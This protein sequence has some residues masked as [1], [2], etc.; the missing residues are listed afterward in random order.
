MSTR[1]QILFRDVHRWTDDDGETQER[2]DEVLTYKHHD[3]YPKGTVPTLRRY[4]QYAG[5]RANDFEYFVASWPYYYKRQK[6]RYD[7]A[8]SYSDLK[9]LEEQET[10]EE[11]RKDFEV[12]KQLTGL[13]ICGNDQFHGDIEYFWVVNLN[14]RV[15]EQYNDVGFSGSDWDSY[16]ELM[17]EKEPVKT[18]ALDAEPG[19]GFG[20]DV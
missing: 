5:A 11:P 2:V 20:G 19:E 18:Y 7:R 1:S 10:P 12:P 4:F 16:K 6:E 13:G 14:E 3:G 17:D 15:I 9:L 8:R